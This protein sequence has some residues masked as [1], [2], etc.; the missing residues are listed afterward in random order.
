M[1]EFL[2]QTGLVT[3]TRSYGDL[4]TLPDHGSTPQRRSSDPNIALNSM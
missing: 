4:T 3:K 1:H 2:Y